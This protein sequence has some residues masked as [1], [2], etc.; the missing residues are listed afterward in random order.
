MDPADPRT[1]A[2]RFAG[3]LAWLNRALAAAAVKNKAAA[4]LIL[5][6]WPRINR[7]A[8]RFTALA[9]RVAAGIAAPRRRTSP[10]PASA[11]PRRP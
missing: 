8:A 9:A 1:P 11:R 3:I 10:R 5:L 2:E 7:L 6:L 4:Q